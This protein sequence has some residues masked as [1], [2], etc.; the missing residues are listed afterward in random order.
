FMAFDQYTR[1]E[2]AK[3]EGGSEEER[4]AGHQLFR[5]ADIRHNVLGRLART[6][7]QA[8]RSPHQ[9]QK[10]APSGG[11]FPFRCVPR[12]LAVHHLVELFGFRQVFETA[13]VIAAAS[14]LQARA[15]GGKVE[16]RLK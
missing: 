10:S 9:F 3:R 7:G 4:L 1:R 14:T 12:K 15:N 2:S 8:E 11:I 13:P 6:S 5:L 16:F